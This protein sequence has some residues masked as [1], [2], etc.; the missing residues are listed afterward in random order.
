VDR[1]RGPTKGD[2]QSNSNR[3]GT[4]VGT[5]SGGAY[6]SSDN[7]SIFGNRNKQSNSNGVGTGSG[8][9][10]HSS[11]SHSILGNRNGDRFG[12]D[13]A[14]VPNMTTNSTPVDGME[15]YRVNVVYIGMRFMCVN[16][17]GF[18]VARGIK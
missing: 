1:S 5:G 4:G 7:N 18:N 2:K 16:G 8:G 17:K 6:H 3:V 14:R 13:A 12:P 10:Y 11:D 15:H 9:A